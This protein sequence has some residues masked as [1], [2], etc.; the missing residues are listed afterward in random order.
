MIHP[1]R[2]SSLT[3]GLYNANAIFVVR[4]DGIPLRTL[5]MRIRTGILLTN[6]LNHGGDIVH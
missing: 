3:L 5:S 4:W 2:K 1:P 6:G